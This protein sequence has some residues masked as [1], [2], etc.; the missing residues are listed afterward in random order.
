VIGVDAAA[1]GTSGFDA[2]DGYAIPINTALGIARQIESGRRSSTAHVGPTAFLGV[3]LRP[4]DYPDDS[5]GAIV[6][7]VAPGTAAERAGIE[8]GDVITRIGG[9]QIDSAARLRNVIL[10]TVPG[11]P[12]RL[13]WTTA[14]TGATR[15]A[16]VRLTAGPPQ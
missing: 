7:A 12:I 16:T 13:A 11:K 15:T 8:G 2:P 14:T 9:R 5:E 10:Q 6:Q 1:S 3:V 4:P